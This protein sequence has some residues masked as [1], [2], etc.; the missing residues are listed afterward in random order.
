MYS[1]NPFLFESKVIPWHIQQKE[2]QA[3][4]SSFYL[5]FEPSRSMSGALPVLLE[6]LDKK[7]FALGFSPCP[8]S[9]SADLC[10]I[11]CAFHLSWTLRNKHIAVICTGQR[12]IRF[13]W[14]LPPHLV[15]PTHSTSQALRGFFS[16]SSTAQVFCI[17]PMN[18]CQVLTSFETRKS[19]S[20]TV[21]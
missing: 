5:N 14:L 12:P 2:P 20:L 1:S 7:P 9:D 6:L 8:V 17:F 16:T 3:T 13:D 10:S 18:D 19:L 4:E 11:H 21:P 15:T